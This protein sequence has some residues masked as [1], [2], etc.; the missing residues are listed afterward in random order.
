[1]EKILHSWSFRNITPIGKVAILK[2]LALSKNTHLLQALPSPDNQTLKNIDKMCTDF[3]WGKK[4]HE[5][6]KQTLNKDIKDGGLKVMPE[7]YMAKKN[8]TGNP[9]LA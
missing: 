6:S 9:R 5:V 8:D 3:I 2:S 7:D 1:M 4:R